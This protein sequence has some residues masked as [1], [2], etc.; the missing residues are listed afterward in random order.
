MF[1]FDFYL[2]NNTNN[3]ILKVL[4][5]YTKYFL[6]EKFE[7]LN[8]HKTAGVHGNNKRPLN[9]NNN[10]QGKAASLDKNTSR[11]ALKNTRSADE[12]KKGR[13]NSQLLFS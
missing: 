11:N 7:A 9:I 1:L 5:S 2:F 6:E 4:L 13:L 12:V 3:F 8:N 10:L